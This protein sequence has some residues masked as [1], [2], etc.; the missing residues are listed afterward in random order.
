MFERKKVIIVLI[1]L[2]LTSGTYFW[3]NRDFK[4]LWFHVFYVVPTSDII[5]I[6]DLIK[7]DFPNARLWEIEDSGDKG[8][9][10]TTKELNIDEHVRIVK[11]M[12]LSGKYKVDE[13]TFTSIIDYWLNR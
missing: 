1:I 8:L 12:S 4:R 11:D 7:K 5:L 9:V 6:E 3:F 10:A 2:V 13:R